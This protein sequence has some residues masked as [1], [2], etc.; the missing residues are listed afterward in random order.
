MPGMRGTEGEP[1]LEKLQVEVANAVSVLRTV[2]RKKKWKCDFGHEHLKPEV[3]TWT[4]LRNQ[5]R[6]RPEASQWTGSVQNI[7]IHELIDKG[8][9]VMRHDLSLRLPKEGGESDST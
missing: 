4:E 6:R 3:F 5:L 7:A 9:L 8:E 2:L 1:L